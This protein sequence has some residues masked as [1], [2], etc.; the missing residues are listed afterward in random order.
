MR[1]T[2]VAVLAVLIGSMQSSFGSWDDLVKYNIEF[3]GIRVPRGGSAFDSPS[4]SDNGSDNDND[5]DNDLVASVSWVDVGTTS[6]LEVPPSPPPLPPTEQSS[7]S[8]LPSMPSSYLDSLTR[9]GQSLYDSFWRALPLPSDG[10]ATATPQQQSSFLDSIRLVAQ[11]LLQQEQD[12]QLQQP[13]EPS[14]DPHAVTPQTDLTRPGRHFTIVTTAA[15][16]WM[17]GTA[18]NPLLRAAY[19]VRK[20]KQINQ[21]DSNAIDTPD[22]TDWQRQ[23][24]TL[25]IPWLELTEDQQEVYN[26]VFD[27]P[28]DQEDYIRTW[29][30]EQADMPDAADPD[31]GM[32]IVFYPARYH[33][34]LKSIFAMGDILSVLDNDDGDSVKDNNNNDD[35]CI[36]E[37][38]EHLNW[39]KA[40]GHGYPQRFRYVIGVVHTNYKEYAATQYHG[41]WTAPALA[42]LSSA[43]VRAYCHKVIKLSD[44]L[45]T[46]AP[47][48]ESTSNVHGVRQDFLSS[49][50]WTHNQGE[51][52]AADTKATTS[53]PTATVPSAPPATQT[54][55]RKA[56]FIGKLLWA[57]GFDTMLVL[58]EYY[59]D[60]T[61][62]YFP[63]D[64]YGSG[65]DQK[66]IRKAFLGRKEVSKQDQRDGNG[67]NENKRN[68]GVAAAT[69]KDELQPRN[70]TLV[71]SSSSSSHSQKRKDL[72]LPFSHSSKEMLHKAK[73]TLDKIRTRLRKTTAE[74]FGDMV[75]LPKTLYE[76]RRNAIP[77]TFPGRVDH[78]LLKDT[79]YTV[80]VNPSVSE[81]LCT[82]TAEALAMGKFV[83]IPVHPSNTF[84][85]KFPNCLAYRNKLE[86]AANLRWAL[87]HDP[88][89]LTPELAREFT[90]EAATDR[91]I[92]AAAVTHAQA[93]GKPHRHY[94]KLDQRIAWFH[95]ELGKGSIGD[96]L[97]KVLGA[98]PASNQVEYVLQQ[99]Q[100]QQQQQGG[101]GE[102]HGQIKRKKGRR[103][104]S[105][106]EK[107][108]KATARG[109]TD[110]DNEND[111]DDGNGGAPASGGDDSD[112]DEI[113]SSK[114]R[115]SV[116][117]EA[118]RNAVPNGLSARTS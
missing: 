12:A 69:T 7:S 102:A 75:D 34:G 28:Q 18:V 6:S 97:R 33:N 31:T 105:D 1:N 3:G 63:I 56:Y 107:R 58:Q 9:F 90:W 86:F 15:L 74:P 49:I 29:L 92:A 115:G 11:N 55:T 88:E 53:S 10:T 100:Q 25:V 26:R 116:L 39:Y 38:P 79:D 16:P 20:T 32:K 62:Q 57:K 96:T 30:R 67:N 76:L 50:A 8:S 52:A 66:E 70:Q 87:T 59:K 14:L 2:L 13:T 77:S 47:D 51:A 110:S 42:L 112:A 43:M 5:N 27:T 23:W 101:E 35:V 71:S 106:V 118:I 61:G 95:N 44:V 94:S 41:L 104:R 117:A 17:T 114:F 85:L 60:C 21:R 68:Q 93:G 22:G 89:P 64:I 36:L 108:R 46:F 37:E 24:V 84:F 73:E 109:G 91:L 78:A 45:Q 65:P 72:S 111:D 80:F 98:G 83:I 81:V 99:Q 82:T 54:K 48:K 113:R 40:P 103:R 4:D 19:L